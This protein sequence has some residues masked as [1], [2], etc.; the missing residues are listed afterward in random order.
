[1]SYKKI[2]PLTVVMKGKISYIDQNHF[3]NQAVNMF[4]S[5]VKLDILPWGGF[6]HNLHLSDKLILLS[7]FV[8]KFLS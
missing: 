2:H 5:V 6:Q 1:M 3:L 8:C 7:A 4:S